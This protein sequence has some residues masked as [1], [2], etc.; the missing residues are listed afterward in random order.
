MSLRHI[1]TVD[2][3]LTLEIGFGGDM[4]AASLADAIIE[5][6]GGPARLHFGDTN[7]DGGVIE[8]AGVVYVKASAN[9]ERLCAIDLWAPE[10][11]EEVEPPE[12]PEEDTGQPEAN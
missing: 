10:P 4:S 9:G 3:T 5:A 2:Q 6:L 7:I 12:I 11:V 8:A 1:R